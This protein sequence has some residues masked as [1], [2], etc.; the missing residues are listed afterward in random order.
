ML[1]VKVT[2]A[3]VLCV[4]TQVLPWP[5]PARLKLTPTSRVAQS[6]LPAGQTGVLGQL[7]PSATGVI[8]VPGMPVFT[9]SCGIHTYIFTYIPTYQFEHSLIFL[10]KY[11]QYLLSVSVYFVSLFT[12]YKFTLCALYEYVCMYV[13][14]HNQRCHQS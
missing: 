1:V 2:S 5:G 7:Y 4:H 11:Y 12:H 3:C 8:P 6:P 14:I 13:S 9:S 10:Y